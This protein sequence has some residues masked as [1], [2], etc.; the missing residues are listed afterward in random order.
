MPFE[1][2]KIEDVLRCPQ[3]RS[4]LVLDEERLVSVDPE[5]RL[6]YPIVD[7]IPRLLP[8]EAGTLSPEEWGGVMER[9]QRNATTGVPVN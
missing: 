5:T 3:T 4:E 7:R 6:A 8:E 9:H 1:Y 2:K